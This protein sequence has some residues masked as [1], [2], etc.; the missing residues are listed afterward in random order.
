M[1]ASLTREEAATRAEQIRVEDYRVTVDLSGAQN[2]ES[3][4]FGSEVTV[5]FTA[6][7]GA[8]TF[9]DFIHD[10]VTEVELNGELLDVD[11][12]VD[13]DRIRLPELG[14]ANELRVVG[15]A[16]YSRSGEGLHLSLIHI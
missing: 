9:I 16:L 1:G 14:Q 6:E 11:D 13:G 4:T 5:R 10:T 8:E 3:T 2:P 7:E 12:V 15:R